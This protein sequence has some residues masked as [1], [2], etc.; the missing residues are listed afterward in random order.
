M[1]SGPRGIRTLRTMAS[2]V[3]AT[4]TNKIENSTTPRDATADGPG[5]ESF[6]VTVCTPEWLSAACREAGGIYNLRHHMVVRLDDFDQRA[7]RSWLEARVE[8]VEAD[9]WTE[10]A[11]R[12][13]RIGHWEFED[14]R[15]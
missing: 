15:R 2:L 3:A 13:G 12:L 10:P 11:G 6:N 14:Y 4:T 9:S 5:E 8:E 7:L 1:H